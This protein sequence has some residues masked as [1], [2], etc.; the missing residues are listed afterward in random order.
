MTRRVAAA[1]AVVALVCGA[2]RAHADGSSAPS[3]V[4]IVREKGA[5]PV[6]IRAG[7]RLAAELRAAGFEVEE[8]VVEADADARGEVEEPGEGGPFATVLLRRSG[9]STATDVW[10]AD[11]VT[12]KTVVRRVGGKGVGDT[13]DRALAMRVVEIMKASLVEALVLPPPEPPEPDAPPPPP[14]PPD[15]AAW[16]QKAIR[17]APVAP[18]RESRLDVGVGV[19]AAFASPDIGVALA[20]ELRVTWRPAPS[21]GL[22]AIAAGPAFGG[23]VDAGDQSATIRQEL[24]LIEASFEPPPSG[25]LAAFAAAGVGVYHLDTTGHAIVPYVG[26]HDEAWAAIGSAGGGLR[27]RLSTGAALVLDARALYA[28]PRPV[29][30]F[31]VQRVA[32]AMHPGMLSALTLTVDL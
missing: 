29:V 4:V 8:R 11:H 1:L 32:A 12:H 6:V 3:R 14:P 23:R 13:S 18:P 9:R 31:G 30:V 27:L 26:E 10:V 28:A 16:T 20:P 25:P 19:A 17:E 24:A 5:D 2:S 15:V 7:L 22:R 21:W